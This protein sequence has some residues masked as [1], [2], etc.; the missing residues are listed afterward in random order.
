MEKVTPVE[1]LVWKNYA[2]LALAWRFTDAARLHDVFTPV[3]RDDVVD[4]D[5][6]DIREREGLD[7]HFAVRSFNL[8]FINDRSTVV[9]NAARGSGKTVFEWQLLASKSFIRRG[10]CVST[11]DGGGEYWTPKFGHDA[12]SDVFVGSDQQHI[13][14]EQLT[15]T[16]RYRAELQRRR[17]FDPR[18]VNVQED[19]AFDPRVHASGDLD[20]I[21][22]SGRHFNI[23]N[24]ATTQRLQRLSPG[25]RDQ[26]EFIVLFSFDSEEVSRDVWRQWAGFLPRKVFMRVWREVTHEPFRALVIDNSPM[27]RFRRPDQ[28]VF[29]FKARRERDV[30]ALFP[31]GEWGFNDTVEAPVDRETRR[32][33]VDLEAF[34]DDAEARLESDFEAARWSLTKRLIEREQRERAERRLADIERLSAS[35]PQ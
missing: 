8:A 9:F 15:R 1:Q 21:A 25:F 26:G 32:P 23:L 24:V 18:C 33:P 35:Q 12:T 2:E 28:R 7:D 17:F 14:E 13:I 11:T 29:W 31:A 20:R 5:I 19:V 27:A 10:Y 30:D 3:D 16:G 22:M 6:A 4:V 34:D